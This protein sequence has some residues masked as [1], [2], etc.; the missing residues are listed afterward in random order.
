LHIASCQIESTT[1]DATAKN[2]IDASS[3]KIKGILS[4][5]AAKVT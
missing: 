3:A 5:V 2:K 4:G 1:T